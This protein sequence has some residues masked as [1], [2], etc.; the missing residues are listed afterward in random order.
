MT[1]DKPRTTSAWSWLVPKWFRKDH[2]LVPVI[3]LSGA[4]GMATPLRPGLSMSAVAGML[5]R[6]F[7]LRG[8]QAVAVAVNSPGG[9]PVQSNLIL[10]RIRALSEEKSI[11]VYTFCEDVAASGGYMLACAGDEIYAD[12]SSIIG[13]IGV[14][15]SGFGFTDAMEKLGVERRVHTAGERKVI[16]DPFQPEKPEDIKQLLAIQK[17]I[18]ELF[19]AL[20]RERRAGVLKGTEKKLFSGEFWTAERARELGLIDG[21]G[22]LRSVMRDK[23][24]ENV[25]LKVMPQEG[26]WLK[27]RLGLR[28]P[29]P[30][31]SLLDQGGRITLA[32][33]L[34][35]AVEARALWSR[36]GL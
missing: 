7:S 3:R 22:D 2:P 16:L 28:G 33:D 5:E 27:R 13:S 10:R 36:F 34:I 14:V 11:P 30:Q 31:W 9:S 23:F 15:S 32:D 35:S 20:V 26:G 6:A 29:L 19:K 1:K 18:H 25:R 17:D 4:I 8:A 21:F 24:G 12:P